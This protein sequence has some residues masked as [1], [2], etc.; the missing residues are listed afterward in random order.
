MQAPGELAP[1]ATAVARA[2]PA[3][4]KLGGAL[5]PARSMFCSRAGGLSVPLKARHVR[6]DALPT[7]LAP[8]P[9]VGIAAAAWRAVGL[10]ITRAGMNDGEV[11][12]NAD[13]DVVFAN[14]FDRRAA[15]DLRQK[16]GTID[17]AAVG[18]GIVKVGREIGVEPGNVG[19][20][21]GSHVIAVE[22]T[23]RREVMLAIRHGSQTPLPR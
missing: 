16:G 21:D 3:A 12:E 14:V 19:L 6:G 13:D 7:S 20:V 4:G 17:K 22:L 10:L 1:G 8:T 23:Q 9:I 15:T 11:A 5:C 18:I 2:S